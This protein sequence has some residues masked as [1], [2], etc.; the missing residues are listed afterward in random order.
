MRSISRCILCVSPLVPAFLL[1]AGSALAASSP[2]GESV[3][4]PARAGETTTDDA[5]I[6]AVSRDVGT[7]SDSEVRA[8]DKSTAVVDAAVLLAG[9]TGAGPAMHPTV[10]KD[11]EGWREAPAAAGKR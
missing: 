1:A 9:V 10:A 4:A 11:A 7:A 5:V 2:L 3:F 6:E 8:A